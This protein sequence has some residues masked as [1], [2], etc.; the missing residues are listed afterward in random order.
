MVTT[1][2]WQVNRK[3]N[4]ATLCVGSEDNPVLSI[5]YDK[6]RGFLDATLAAYGAMVINSIEEL[7]VKEVLVREAEEI[8][9][10][11]TFAS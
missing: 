9:Q 10:G 3:S 4:V 5:P 11:E 8:I 2:Y 7:K 6:F 1:I